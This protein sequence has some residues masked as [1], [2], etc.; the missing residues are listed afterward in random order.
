MK[1]KEKDDLFQKLNAEYLEVL[2]KLTE[3][4]IK[5]FEENYEIPA[6]IENMMVLNS[7]DMCF[8]FK[9]IPDMKPTTGGY[10]FDDV[11]LHPELLMDLSIDDNGNEE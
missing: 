7:S 9:D 3:D 10:I 8:Y 5:E 6:K 11:N 1:Q 4:D 2:S